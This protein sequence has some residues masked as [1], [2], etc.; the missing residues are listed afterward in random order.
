MQRKPLVGFFNQP[1]SVLSLHSLLPPNS[2]TGSSSHTVSG[3]PHTPFWLRH[4]VRVVTSLF[5]LPVLSLQQNEVDKDPK[6][7]PPKHVVPSED[8]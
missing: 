8:H 1:Q 2:K 6:S 3:Q 5:R 4:A 7:D